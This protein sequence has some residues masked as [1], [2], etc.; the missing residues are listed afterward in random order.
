MRVVAVHF[1]TH[2]DMNHKS[3]GLQHWYDSN[4]RVASMTYNGGYL[5]VLEKEEEKKKESTPGAR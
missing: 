1:N 2:A 4:W 5:V 3:H